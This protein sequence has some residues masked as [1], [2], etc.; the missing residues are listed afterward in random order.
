MSQSWVRKHRLAYVVIMTPVI[1]FILYWH[2]GK[3]FLSITA[4]VLGSVMAYKL[5][6]PLADKFSDYLDNITVDFFKKIRS[7]GTKD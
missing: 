5:L 1:A 4:S 2:T 6:F 7:R 3:P